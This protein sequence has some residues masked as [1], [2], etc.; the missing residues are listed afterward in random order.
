MGSVYGKGFIK[1]LKNYIKNSDDPIVKKA[2]ISLVADFD[3][4]QANT[5]YGDA[6]PNDFTQQF[7][8]SGFDLFGAGWLANK[9]SK[10][11]QDASV[12]RDKSSH[13]ISS[14]T[15]DISRLKEGTYKWNG[16]SWVCQDCQN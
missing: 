1:A 13:F 6:D 14:F 8:H 5:S 12:S 7:T 16:S 4:F 15:K 10:N 2:L 11:A 3:P 9:Q